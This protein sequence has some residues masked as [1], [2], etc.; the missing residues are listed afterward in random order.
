MYL[1]YRNW[2]DLLR[3]HQT[4]GP[5]TLHYGLWLNYQTY[6]RYNSEIDFSDNQAWN[7]SGTY[8]NGI[9]K[10]VDRL[11]NGTFTTAQPYI[12]YDWNLTS[13]LQCAAA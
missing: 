11:I 6:H 9:S 13:Q 3:V 10:A 4:F 12:Q 5:G 1:N 8:P 7:A 2:G